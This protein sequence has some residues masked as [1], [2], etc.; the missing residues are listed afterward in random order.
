MLA[1]IIVV[2]LVRCS[3]VDDLDDP[4]CGED[5]TNDNP[6]TVHKDIAMLGDDMYV[7]RDDSWQR[8]VARWR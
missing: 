8:H 4:F 6:G 3:L 1:E 2:K 7:L 5:V